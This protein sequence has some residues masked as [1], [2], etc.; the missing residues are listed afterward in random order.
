[1]SA[2][3]ERPWGGLFAL[4]CMLLLGCA[5]GYL[6]LVSTGWKRRVEEDRG[7]SALLGTGRGKELPGR[8]CCGGNRTPHCVGATAEDVQ[9][10]YTDLIQADIPCY[11][12]PGHEHVAEG[13][14][15]A[16]AGSWGRGGQAP[17]YQ[18]VDTVVVARI[19]S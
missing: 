3:L 2:C 6:H 1:M 13:R 5:S 15:L 18:A 7:V 16:R 14:M 9:C 8:S 17:C 11:Q 10:S 19:P 4:L 12:D